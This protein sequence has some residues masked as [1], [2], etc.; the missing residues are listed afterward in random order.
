MA[1]NRATTLPYRIWIYVRDNPDIPMADIAEAMDLPTTS[2]TGPVSALCG[3]GKLKR[4]GRRG[5]Y[6]YSIVKDC[7]PP[8][9]EGRYVERFTDKLGSLK[10][11]SSH[12]GNTIFDECRQNWIGYELNKL[13]RE[14]R[15]C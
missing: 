14:V 5:S 1:E 10:F 9:P 8:A 4:T 7:I 15:A 3:R 12:D 6:L 13:L 11:I 2:T